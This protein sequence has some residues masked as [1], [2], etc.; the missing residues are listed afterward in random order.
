[1]PN[2]QGQDQRTLELNFPIK[3]LNVSLYSRQDGDEALISSISKTFNIGKAKQT[4][5][6]GYRHAMDNNDWAW[7]LSETNVGPV[8][9]MGMSFQPLAENREG[10]KPDALNVWKVGAEIKDTYLSYSNTAGRNQIFVIPHTK[11]LKAINAFT[12]DK[13][14]WNAFSQFG[15]GNA[16]KMT[17][18]GIN[19]ATNALALPV[20]FPIYLPSFA[21]FGD[22]NGRIQA[23][24]ASGELTGEALAGMKTK[25]LAFSLGAKKTTEGIEPIA[26][27]YKAFEKGD[28]GG[29][30]DLRLSPSN[31]FGYF[32]LSYK[33]R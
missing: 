25:P 26:H 23:S 28:F 17:R 27:F 24:N 4:L 18:E 33:V 21:G 3:D 5:N 19:G 11:N 10:A 9:L 15:I 12:E 14:T 30:V 29:S 16:A 31:S 8:D 20:F 6:A 32:T 22:F 7:L 1:L 13:G 2:P